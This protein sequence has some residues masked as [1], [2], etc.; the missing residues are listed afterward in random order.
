MEN[1]Q[2]TILAHFQNK[3][4]TQL[5]A[6]EIMYGCFTVGLILIQ[7]LSDTFVVENDFLSSFSSTT[8][9]YLE[10]TTVRTALQF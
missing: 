5:E 8:E 2:S 9:L 6:S 10:L 1:D 7:F 3:Q 4:H